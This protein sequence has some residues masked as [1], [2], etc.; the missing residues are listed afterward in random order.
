MSLKRI[1]KVGNVRRSRGWIGLMSR[2]IS[3]YLWDLGE[4]GACGGHNVE[5]MLQDPIKQSCAAF[6]CCRPDWNTETWHILES[7][8]LGNNNW[9]ERERAQNQKVGRKS[10]PCFCFEQRMC[11]HLRQ[12]MWAHLRQSSRANW[13]EIKNCRQNLTFGFTRRPKYNVGIIQILLGLQDLWIKKQEKFVPWNPYVWL[14]QSMWVNPGKRR[15]AR[16]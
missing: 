4:C 11:V 6:H 9:N 7:A 10:E 1:L 13:Q 15:L 16:C 14:E 12:R 3:W 8:W 5:C 2:S